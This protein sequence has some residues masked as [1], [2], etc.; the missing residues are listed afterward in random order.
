MIDKYITIKEDWFERLNEISKS[1]EK[2]GKVDM[3]VLSMLLG[4]ISSVEFIVH[5][6]QSEKKEECTATVE[7]GGKTSHP[8][9]CCQPSEKKEGVKVDSADYTEEQL[10]KENVKTIDRIM[11]C[12]PSEPK[13]EEEGANRKHVGFGPHKGTPENCHVCLEYETKDCIHHTFDEPCPY[14]KRG[15]C[16]GT[17]IPPKGSTEDRSDVY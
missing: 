15:A 9:F 16:A 17:Y 14:C 8:D 3:Q 7:L 4:Y 10:F 1:V 12:Q 13:S 6:N 2:N 11:V 5:L